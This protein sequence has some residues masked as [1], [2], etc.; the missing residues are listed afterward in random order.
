MSKKV[1]VISSSPR[2]GGN[3]DVL[4][5]AFVKG[6]AEAGHD[7]EKINL[8]GKT[9]EFCKG[10]F[11]CM[12]TKRCVIRDDADQ[13]EQKMQDADVLV[14]ASPIYYYEMC[15][16]LKTMLDRGNP[17]YT[18]DYKFRDVYFLSTA[19]ENE[20]FVPQRALSGVEGWVACFPKARL[21]GSVFAGGITNMGEIAG[22]PSLETAYEMG[23]AIQ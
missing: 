6:A 5:E 2:I 15:G 10:C 16:Q 19:A 3:S 9:I 7:V 23:K 12:T 20:A 22:H 1:L 13:I 18:T 17:L 21:A 11:V 8:A 14:F 4:A